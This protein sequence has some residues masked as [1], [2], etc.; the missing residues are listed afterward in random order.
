MLPIHT[1]EANLAGQWALYKPLRPMGTLAEKKNLSGLRFQIGFHQW[2]QNC[3]QQHFVHKTATRAMS[4]QQL[5]SLRKERAKLKP[6]SSCCSC[7]WLTPTTSLTRVE[8]AHDDIRPFRE[9]TSDPTIPSERPASVRDLEIGPRDCLLEIGRH[10]EQ[11][12]SQAR[13]IV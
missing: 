11:C 2:R 9:N 4:R 1:T 10:S 12:W 3:T 5:S 8:K 7:R 6:P 13:R